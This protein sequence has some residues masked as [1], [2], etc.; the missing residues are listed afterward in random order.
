MNRLRQMRNDACRPTTF[1]QKTSTSSATIFRS[2]YR[3]SVSVMMDTV[4]NVGLND[5]S[6]GA[7][8]RSSGSCQFAYDS[9]CRLSQFDGEG[10]A[11]IDRQVFE[12]WESKTSVILSISLAQIRGGSCMP[13][14]P[15]LSRPDR[16]VTFHLLRSTDKPNRKH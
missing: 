11:G 2:K 13:A 8:A 15:G 5:E 1:V 9:Y 14:R 10:V 3:A 7:P 6:V 12:S 16:D 4:L